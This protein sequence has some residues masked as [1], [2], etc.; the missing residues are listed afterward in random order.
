MTAVELAKLRG[1]MARTCGSRDVAIALMDGPVACN[2]PDLVAARIQDVTGRQAGTCTQLKGSACGHGTFVAGILVAKRGSRAPAI[3]PD[4]T[5]IL[6]P[7]FKEKAS[8]GDLP[9]ASPE[10]L[11]QAIIE[12]VDAGARVVNLSV[13]TKPSIGTERRIQDSLQYAARRGALVVAAAGNHGT[14]GSSAITRHPWVIPVVAVDSRGRPM[15]ESNLA[16][17]IGRRGLGA[18][19]EAVESLGAQGAPLTLEGT[20]AAAAFVTG[21]IA[22]LWSEFPAA[23]AG[24]VRRAVTHRPPRTAV[25]PPLLDAGAAYDFI[26]ANG[27]R[28]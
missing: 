22:L 23:S 14:L 20:S 18:P 12:S 19:G 1:L 28:G 3:C 21:T 16:G 24:E 25:T 9:A 6:R 7:I 17:S 2:H 26:A 4:C 8:S 10:E 13:G 11:A 27:G 5:L 15:R